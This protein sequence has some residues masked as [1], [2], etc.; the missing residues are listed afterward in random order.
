MIERTTTLPRRL[1]EY[2]SNPAI[3][4]TQRRIRDDAVNG[5]FPAQQ[6]NGIWHY[7]P[8]DVPTIAAVYGLPPK[9]TTK[10]VKLGRKAASTPVS[11]AA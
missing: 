9:A 11:T 8:V 2:T 1:I 5:K 4:P 6:I 7:D 10:T 3:V